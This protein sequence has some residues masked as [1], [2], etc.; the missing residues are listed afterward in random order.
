MTN[1]KSREFFKAACC[2]FAAVLLFTL[3]AGC[4]NNKS[5]AAPAPIATSTPVPHQEKIIFTYNGNM[6]WMDSD[7]GNRQE[8]FPDSNSKWFPAVS[9]DGSF[10]AYWVQNKKS[11]NVWL[12][13]LNKKTAYPV[14][15]DEDTV[16]GDLQNF[17]FRN[18]PCFSPDSQ[19]ILYGRRGDIWRMT[20]DGY[21][22][23]ALTSTH[24]CISPVLS[25]DNRLVFVMKESDDTFNLYIQDLNGQQPEKL[26]RQ[27]SKK[28]GSPAFSPDGRK[29]IYTVQDNDSVNIFMVDIAGRNEDQL[30]FDGKSNAP[31]FSSDGAKIIY[32]SFLNNKYQPEIWEM[33]Y[34]KTGKV[35]LTNDG[36]VSPVWLYRVLAAPVAAN[37][38]VA[39]PAVTPKQENVFDIKETTSNVAHS[40]ATPV[41]SA[42]P[43]S[44]ANASGGLKVST[45]QQ[46]NKLLFYPVIHYDPSLSN[47]KPEF[48]PALDDMA[49]IMRSNNSPIIIEGHTDNTPIKTK[50]FP[51]NYELSVARADAVKDY[52]VRKDGISASRITVTGFGD[53]KPAA[54]NDSESNK[55]IN[56]RSE[57]MVI[58]VVSEPI[59]EPAVKVTIKTLQP[60]RDLAPVNT[61][62][63]F[64]VSAPAA[65]TST[66]AVS[67]VTPETASPVKVQMK[68]P[69]SSKSI[70]W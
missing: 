41:P 49:N 39:S 29:V 43:N 65:E 67:A 25:K 59:T 70:S 3:L 63:P 58:S 61:P 11:Y 21:D 46:G 19:Y 34:D 48:K 28:V 14:T 17:N 69:G 18:A 33:N 42:M 66:A 12:A 50:K 27:S 15:F 22:Q 57:I 51:S 68:S 26:T 38:A 37:T 9:P 2:A 24:N 30:T 1:K 5:K 20:R 60:S 55:Y 8:I 35:K 10:I 32:S 45:V 40:P 64:T 36:G 62:A 16:D 23:T 52:L 47:I 56:R 4:N 6:Y 7:G 31:C 54:P 53:T 44:A 13:D